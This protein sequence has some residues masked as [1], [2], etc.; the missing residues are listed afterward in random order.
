[1]NGQALAQAIRAHAP[2]ASTPILAVSGD[3]S[4]SLLTRA[5]GHD[6]TDYFD[7]REGVAALGAFLRTHLLPQAPLEGRVFHI[8]DSRVIAL[9]TRRILEKRGATVDGVGTAEEAIAILERDRYLGLHRLPHVVLTDVNLKGD[10]TGLDVIAHLRG[11]MG[12]TSAVMPVVVTTGDENPHHQAE[13]IR[14]GADDLVEKPVSEAVLVAK[15]RFHMWRSQH[16]RPPA[17]G[18]SGA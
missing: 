8:E 4:E 13:L 11:P 2:H 5:M 6:I 18:P 1:M 17:E 10:E 14:A 3:V 15:L 12:L 7:K 9:T 16:A